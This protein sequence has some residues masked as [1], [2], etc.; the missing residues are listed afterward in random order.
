MGVFK[1]PKLLCKEIN[2]AMDRFWWGD[3]D[4]QRRMHWFAWWRMCIPKKKLGGM[5]L[6]DL[7]TFNMA[8]IAK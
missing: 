5:G 8:M 6:C 7:H 3:S 2:D 4:E 1:I